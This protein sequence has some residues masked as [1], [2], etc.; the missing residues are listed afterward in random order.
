[1]AVLFHA[2]ENRK[3]N[4]HFKLFC[5]GFAVH[6]VDIQREAR[7]MAFK[8]G[9]RAQNGTKCAPPGPEYDKKGTLRR[10]CHSVTG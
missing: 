10:C 4:T 6:Y 7:Q 9:Q 8:I 5:I 3:R 2:F 1:M